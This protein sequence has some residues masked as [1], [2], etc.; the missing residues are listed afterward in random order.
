[1]QDERPVAFFSKLLGPKAQLK[2]IYEKELMAICLPVQKWRYY[3]LGR[4]FLVKTDQQSLKF[5]MQQREIGVDYQKWVNKEV[6][7]DVLLNQIKQDLTSTTKM[8]HG[9]TINDVGGHAGD[10]KTYLRIAAEWFW[11]GIWKDVATF[12]QQCEVCQRQKVSQQAL[13]GLL[14]PLPIPARIWED[15]S[16]DFIEGLPNSQRLHGFP[17]SII[18]D[19]DRIF[20]NSFWKELFRLHNT[21][22]KRSTSYH[23]QTD[24]QTEIVNKMLETYLRCFVGGQPKSWSKWLH[25]AEFS[26]NTS[27][28]MSTKLTPFKVV[29]GRDPLIINRIGKGQSPI[30]SIECLLQERDATLDDLRFNLLK[31]QQKMKLNADKNRRDDQFE[32]G[33]HVY[34]KIQPYQLIVDVGKGSSSQVE[35][36]LKW[37]G[38]PLFKATWEEAAAIDAQFPD[39]H[40]EDK[41][42][43]WAPSNVTNGEIAQQ[44]ITYTRRQHKEKNVKT[45]NKGKIRN[46]Q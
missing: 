39:F 13:A 17:G 35:V 9:F 37:K 3:L 15:I 23:P 30:D 31:A 8:H 4:H 10:I 44:L 46:V 26:Y 32:I 5:I 18:S 29:Y 42:K 34:V 45:A 16:L 19:R 7:Q 22:I 24:G 40:L 41:V 43:F 1:M 27:S 14:Q 11:V 12:V 2:S 28:H 38:L 21:E 6:D 33:Q 25:W 20:L 36:L